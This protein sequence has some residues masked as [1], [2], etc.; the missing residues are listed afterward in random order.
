MK[1]QSLS[2]AVNIMLTPQ[3]YTL[4]REK[5]PLKYLYQAKNIAT[6]LFDG[7]LENAQKYDYL[8]YKEKDEWIFL[9]Y[10]LEAISNFLVSKGI[11]LEQIGKIF[12][13]QQASAYFTAPVL[14][15][16]KDALVSL[17]NTVVIIPQNALQNKSGILDFDNS[18]TP[19]TGVTPVGTHSSVLRKKQTIGLTVFFAL[20]AFM[21]FVEGWR[22]S[23]NSQATQEEMQMLLEEH[24]SLQSQYTRE[25]IAVKYKTIDKNERRKREIVKVLAG[26]IFKG[27]KVASF[28]LNEKAFKVEFSCS[29]AKVAKRLAE[30]AKKVKFTSAKIIT[31]NSVYIE[32]K[33]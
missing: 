4:K 18:F 31:G 10:D 7:F 11:K 22:Y 23:H 8:V 15:G 17:D 24:P 3:F 27:V 13:A 33:L 28:D 9:A 6:S 19:K 29:N 26:M 30:L 32:E 5:L 14:L 1:E 20:F 2:D 16:E 25:S 21:F 12:F